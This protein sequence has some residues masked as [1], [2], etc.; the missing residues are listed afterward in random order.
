ME[1]K[2]IE[3][4]YYDSAGNKRQTDYRIQQK[5]SFLGIKHLD[6]WSYL[7]QEHCSVAGCVNVHRTF[8]SIELA[9]DYIREI[10]ETERT[11]KDN[12][13]S[14]TIKTTIKILSCPE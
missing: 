10:C 4:I 11:N 8:S 9:E 14:K 6:W 5:K 3:F 12:P 7:T 13:K 2:I 1:Y